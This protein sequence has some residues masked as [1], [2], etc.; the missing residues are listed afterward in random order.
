MSRAA[1][2]LIELI[3]SMA[4]LSV[5]LLGAM[6]VFP[7]GLKA[8]QRAE[9]NSRAAIAAQRTIESLKLKP[10]DQLPEQPVTVQEEGFEIS[11]Q[12]FRPDVERLADPDRLKAV[13]V[14]VRSS[15]EGRAREWTFLTYVRRETS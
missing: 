3:I 7:L 14:T 11:T 2:S 15:Q 9:L 12:V 10:W 8:S 4:I 5:G 13:Q 6:R 1:F